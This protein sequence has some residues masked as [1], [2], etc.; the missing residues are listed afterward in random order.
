[1][2]WNFSLFTFVFALFRYF[3]LIY[4][5]RRRARA[6]VF[7][8]VNFVCIQSEFGSYKSVEKLPSIFTKPIIKSEFR[9]SL[10]HGD[11]T[12]L[13]STCINTKTKM[14]NNKNNS[15]SNSHINE[16][17]S[18]CIDLVWCSFKIKK[19]GI[20][21]DSNMQ[22]HHSSMLFMCVRS[23]Q[24]AVMCVCVCVTGFE[25]AKRDRSFASAHSF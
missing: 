3:I 1:M 18:K 13:L 16:N 5:S 20:A 11:R 7:R 6:S 24:S 12:R 19:S 21:Q 14:K 15:N 22:V 23:A 25:N 4:L 17:H 10:R 8:N 9:V 2:G